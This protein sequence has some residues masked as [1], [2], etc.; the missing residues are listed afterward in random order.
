MNTPKIPNPGEQIKAQHIADIIR[1]VNSL[2]P[3]GDGKTIG[4][5]RTAGGSVLTSLGSSEGT[6]AVKLKLGSH[7]SGLQYYAI[8]YD[9]DDD[10]LSSWTPCVASSIVDLEEEDLT[11]IIITGFNVG[12]D[13]EI[14]GEMYPL[15]YFDIP[16]WL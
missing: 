3:H 13:V 9:I 15:I 1:W 5:T 10:T 7:L 4:V 14:S 2:V 11:D 16:R 12:L 6:L 8:Y